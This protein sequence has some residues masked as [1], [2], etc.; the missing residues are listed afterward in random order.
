MGGG[1]SVGQLV[2]V[3]LVG[4]LGA[5]PGGGTDLAPGRARLGGLDRDLVTAPAGGLELQLSVEGLVKQP[6][7]GRV[8]RAPGSTHPPFLSSQPDRTTDGPNQGRLVERPGLTSSPA[9]EVEAARDGRGLVGE[10][11]HLDDHR[12]G[13][14]RRA[15]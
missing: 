3:S 4:G 12:G 1:L 15:P 11:D 10:A 9:C 5:H 7:G 14:A 6:A 13:L 2:A 8:K